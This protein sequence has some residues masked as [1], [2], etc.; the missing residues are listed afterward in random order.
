VSQAPHGCKL[1]VERTR[2]CLERHRPENR[3]RPK[4]QE[5]LFAWLHNF[6]R[7]GH[8]LGVSRRQLP[9]LIQ[10]ACILIL[11]KNY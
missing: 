3:R 2:Y 5:R 4:T 1:L 11:L 9:R 10:L 6:R 7:L 8:P